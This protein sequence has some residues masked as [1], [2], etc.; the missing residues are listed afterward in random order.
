MK[1]ITVGSISD[2]KLHI[3]RFLELNGYNLEMDTDDS[4]RLFFEIYD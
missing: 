2:I 4:E 1:L 3:Q